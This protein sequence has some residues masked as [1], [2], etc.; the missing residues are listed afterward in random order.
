ML[1]MRFA[2][3]SMLTNYHLMMFKDLRAVDV[4]MWWFHF[5]FTFLFSQQAQLKKRLDAE[6]QRKDRTRQDMV[7]EATE[8]RKLF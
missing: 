7:E 5:T 2:E 3:H 1:I 8:F 4:I 6:E